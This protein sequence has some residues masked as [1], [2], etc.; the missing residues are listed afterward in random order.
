MLNSSELFKN[1]QTVK[2]KKVSIAL[3]RAPARVVVMVEHRQ[4]NLLHCALIHRRRAGV[5]DDP[6]LRII[7]RDSRR[8][9]KNHDVIRKLLDP[10]LIEEQKIA[11]LRVAAVTTDKDCIVILQRSAIG[12]L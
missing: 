4:L 5:I 10:G 12:K 1:L 9:E 3:N 7:G 2:P 11:G 8:A 6:V